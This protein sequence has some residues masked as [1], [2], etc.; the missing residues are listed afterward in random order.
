[1]LFT[2][3]D[4]EEK[5]EKMEQLMQEHI[6]ALEENRQYYQHNYSYKKKTINKIDQKL[7]KKSSGSKYSMLLKLLKFSTKKKTNTKRT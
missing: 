2:K 4:Q 6:K 1:M 7:M 3:K 5:H